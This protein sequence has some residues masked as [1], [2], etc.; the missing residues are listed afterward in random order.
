M[1]HL[2]RPW[3]WERLKAGGDEDNRGWDGWIAS[4]TWWRRIWINS[5]SWWWT[6]KPGLQSMGSQRVAH[7]W[8][9]EL[10]WT[11]SI[12]DTSLA[13]KTTLLEKECIIYKI[14]KLRSGIIIKDYFNEEKINNTINTKELDIIASAKPNQELGGLSHGAAVFV[15]SF[16]APFN[17]EPYKY[18]TFI[19]I[20]GNFWSKIYTMDILI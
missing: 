13:L 18:V 9:T 17:F 11:F 14:N 5:G 8:E 12:T 16:L 20:K 7:D 4:P 6:G 1:I 3:C 10:N 15:I 2:N 19:K